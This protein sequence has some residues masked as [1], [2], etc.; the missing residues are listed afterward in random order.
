SGVDDLGLRW[1]QLR[2]HRRIV[3]EHIEPLRRQKILGSSLEAAVH[4]VFQ[5]C[6]DLE[7]TPADELAELFITSVVSYERGEPKSGAFF[8]P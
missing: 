6:P 8:L 2:A 5:R 1:E 7:V 4:F 3:S